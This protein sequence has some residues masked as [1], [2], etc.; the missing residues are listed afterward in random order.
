M[1]G[2]TEK[3]WHWYQDG[4]M[5]KKANTF[6]DFIAAAEHLRAQGYAGRIVAHGGSAGGLLVGA[7]VNMRP[8]LFAGMI[9]D[10][11]FVDVINTMSDE[12]LPLTPPEWQEWGN[13]ITDAQAFR[14]MLELFALRERARAGLSGDP[15]ARRADRSARRAT[16]SRPS[17]SRNCARSTPADS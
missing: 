11:P 16:G 7:S 1:R 2:G 5:E 4:K 6:T 14:T 12:T 15:R 8:D 17:G 10:V 3:G 9:A 13:P